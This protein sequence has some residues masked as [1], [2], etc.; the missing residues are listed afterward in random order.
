MQNTKKWVITAEDT[1][2]IND[3]TISKLSQQ[4]EFSSSYLVLM[5]MSGL[6]AAIALL[7]NSIPILIG[8]MIIA[9][10]F[11]PLSLV[12][13]A[14]VGGKPRLAMRGL[15]VALAGL[16][17][18]MLLAMVTTWLLKFSHILPPEINLM[19]KPLL[20]ERVNPGW[21]SIAVAVSAGVAGTIAQVRD[22]V[23][24]LVGA[25]AAVALVPAA[26]AAAI[27]F[28]SHDPHLGIGGLELLAINISSIIF[29]GVLTILVMGPEQEM[30]KE[31]SPEED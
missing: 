5:S 7:N 13:F 23:D 8:S 11:A 6:L 2:V 3:F 17:M 14:L 15:G 29:A 12:A 26:A 16:F 24:T 4:V 28:I 19:E 31:L 22:K 18:A 25:V 10:A 20:D 21:Y 27:A 9:P 30:S 1:P